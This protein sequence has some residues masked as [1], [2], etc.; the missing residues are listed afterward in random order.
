MNLDEKPTFESSG[1]DPK[2]SRKV[3]T[4]AKVATAILAELKIIVRGFLVI[5][6]DENSPSRAANKTAASPSNI[7]SARKMKMS[8]IEMYESNR[9]NR[10]TIREPSETVTTTR[11]RK[12]SPI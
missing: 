9:K 8:D 7:S 10:T 6:S 11:R 3:H 2:K 12:G 5:L 4:V 1:I